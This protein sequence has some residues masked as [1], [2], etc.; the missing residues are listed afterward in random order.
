MHHRLD[1]P[2]PLPTAEAAPGE[3]SPETVVHVVHVAGRAADPLEQHPRLRAVMR[4]V[5]DHVRDE[6]RE[7]HLV[8]MAL[9]VRV[10][11]YAIGAR[12]GQR[13]DERAEVCVG[14]GEGL[15]PRALDRIGAAWRRLACPTGEPDPRRPE[16][17]VQVAGDSAEVRVDRPGK[18]LRHHPV[19]RRQNLVVRPLVVR[20]ELPQLVAVRHGRSYLSISPWRPIGW[21]TFRAM[22]AARRY[23]VITESGTSLRCLILLNRGRG[24]SDHI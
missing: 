19:Y 4:P 13:L 10:G 22:R 9:G 17:V 1:S 18:L 21:S 24:F 20:D 23:A 2:Y 8:R 16:H 11:D 7:H 3:L 12:I 6:L 5:V 14:L 15:A